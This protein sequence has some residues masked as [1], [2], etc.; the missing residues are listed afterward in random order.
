[1]DFLGEDIMTEAEVETAVQEYLSLIKALGTFY[2]DA[3]ASIKLSAI[4]LLVSPDLTRQNLIRLLQEAAE[5][6]NIKI[7]VDME[8]SRYTQVTLDL[9]RDL[10]Q[11][12]PAIST[13]IQSYLRRS[14]KDI[15]DLTADGISIRLVKGAY[16]EVPLVA[17][18]RKEDVDRQYRQQ[19]FKLLDTGIHPSIATHDKSLIDACKLYAKKQS[20]P[21]DR[22]EFEML[23]GVRRDLQQ[24]LVKDKYAVRV[25]IPYGDQWYPYF[26]RR[27][28]E[29]P[30]NL[31]FFLKN[32]T[33]G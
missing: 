20:I 16:S 1:M 5:R 33:K 4:G 7:R 22:F 30:A 32:L 3:Y 19:M 25:Y 23:L 28:A 27:L 2:Q 14:D 26:S 6:G 18:Q 11:T 10:H 21:S 24:S 13:V 15:A 12:F 9:V 17:F 29:R 8:S 31:G